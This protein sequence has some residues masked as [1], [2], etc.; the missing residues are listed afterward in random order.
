M[1]SEI[2]NSCI[3]MIVFGKVQG[4]FFRKHT[5]QKAIELNIDGF[6][7]NQSDQ[8]VLIHACGEKENLTKFI[9]WCKH[10]P[11][12]AKVSHFELDEIN[13]ESTFTTFNILK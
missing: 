2:R 11:S 9:D 13:L 12:K 1:F 6:V 4:V 5:K 10:G 3:R 7:K 8:S